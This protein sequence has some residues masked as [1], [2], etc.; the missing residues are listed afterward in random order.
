MNEYTNEEYEAQQI[1]PRVRFEDKS[2]EDNINEDDLEEMEKRIMH[3]M[4][5]VESRELER[6]KVSTFLKR[7]ENTESFNDVTICMMEVPVKEHKKPE[8]VEAK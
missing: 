6:D 8:V 7:V 2:F 4:T 3:S 1:E 5:G